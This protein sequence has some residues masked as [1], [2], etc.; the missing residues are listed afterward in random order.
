MPH[1]GSVYT[2]VVVDYTQ[3]VLD[4]V[5][6]DA[7]CFVEE[8]ASITINGRDVSDWRSFKGAYDDYLE[9]QLIEEDD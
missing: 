8:D 4:A 3:M 6:P 5:L 9:N 1:I 2:S 7:D